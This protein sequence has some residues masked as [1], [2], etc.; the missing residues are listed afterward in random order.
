MP[1]VVH[2][3]GSH[4]GNGGVG[5]VERNAAAGIYTKTSNRNRKEALS[6]KN[7]AGEP[8]FWQA[9]ISFSA[10]MWHMRQLET[11]AEAQKAIAVSPGTVSSAAHVVLHMFCCALSDLAL[12]YATT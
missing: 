5:V 2:L 1:K 12:R 7:H 9:H 6:T 10:E 11:G 4:V 3:S 8:V